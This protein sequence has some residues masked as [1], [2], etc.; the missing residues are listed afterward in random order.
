LGVKS[1]IWR[2]NLTSLPIQKRRLLTIFSTERRCAAIMV[3]RSIA[4][5]ARGPPA[6]RRIFIYFYLFL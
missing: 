2:W 6:R 4:A 5:L 1:A 3:W